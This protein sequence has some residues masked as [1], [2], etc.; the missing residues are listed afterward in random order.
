M[1]TMNGKRRMKTTNDDIEEPV[2][3]SGMLLVI[4]FIILA[5]TVGVGIFLL[6]EALKEPTTPEEKLDM[7]RM[8]VSGVAV[9]L[10]STAIIFFLKSLYKPSKKK[11]SKTVFKKKPVKRKI[12]RRKTR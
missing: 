7:N 11:I 9:I 3:K 6:V 12:A 2:R 10:F 4:S 1:R 8:M 5:L